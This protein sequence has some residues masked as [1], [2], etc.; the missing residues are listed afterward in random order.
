[1]YLKKILPYP[2]GKFPPPTRKFPTESL[3]VFYEPNCITEIYQTN[4]DGDAYPLVIQDK[5]CPEVFNNHEGY[6]L[7]LDVQDMKHM[8]DIMAGSLDEIKANWPKYISDVG[9][10]EVDKDTFRK[11][12]NNTLFKDGGQWQFYRPSKGGEYSSAYPLFPPSWE[13]GLVPEDMEYS[14]WEKLSDGNYHS[15]G[16]ISE[17]EW[18]FDVNCDVDDNEKVTVM[19]PHTMQLIIGTI[20]HFIAENLLT[21]NV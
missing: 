21:V 12:P 8:R 4:H 9:V 3:F 1:M 13:D 6:I 10:I 14:T 11:L 5:S 19:G 7:V 2:E 16:P 15:V 18:D 20:E 17:T